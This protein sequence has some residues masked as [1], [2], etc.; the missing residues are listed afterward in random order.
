MGLMTGIILTLLEIP[1]LTA[2]GVAV[3]AC[4]FYYFIIFKSSNPLS[5]YKWNKYNYIW[6]LLLFI[7]LGQFV[8]YL[9]QPTL[10]EDYNKYKV[11]SGIISDIT[12]STSGDRAVVK[13]ERLIDG[14]GKS[15]ENSIIKILLKTDALN[16][17]I[18]DR[19]IFPIELEEIKDSRNYFSIGYTDFLKRKGIYYETFSEGEKIQVIDHSMTFSGLATKIR[20]NLESHIENTHLSK[21]TQN[22]L[23]TVLLGDRSYLDNQ[24]RNLFADAGISHILALSGMHIV[25]IGGI[26]LWLLFPLN[27]FGKYKLRLI[28]TMLLM[29]FYAYITGLNPSTVRATLMMT[30]VF[31][32]ILIERKNTAW[33]SLLL[34]TFII[35]LFN[36]LSLMDV[37]L[38]LSFIC[39]ASLIFFVRQLNPFEQHQH[40]R[41]YKISNAIITTLA[42]TF[43]TW[44]VT[45]Y[46][47]GNVPVVFFFANIIVLPILPIY[48]VISII[49]FFLFGAGIDAKFL[50]NVLD[51][52]YIK[53]LDIVKF[54]SSDGS[55]ALKFSP[56]LISV[57]L[58]CML[59]IV[60]ILIINKNKSR[61]Y[62][63]SGFALFSFFIVSIIFT[64]NADNTDGFIVQNGIGNV[65][66]LTRINGEENLHKIDKQGITSCDILGH[67]LLIMDGSIDRFYGKLKCDE[68]I[69]AGGCKEELKEIL[70]KIAAKEIIIHPSIRKKREQSLINEADSLK[71][72][73]HSI[74]N[75]GPYRK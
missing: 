23:I 3:F 43:A 1:V 50:G 8:S 6:I 12:Q 69:I 65:R 32:C 29:F 7:S 20:D 14:R 2:A 55:T 41:L 19:I 57:V 16:A 58:W 38:Q 27:F 40:P 59:V 26:F 61:I 34:A 45:G 60:I 28:L 44:C 75:D 63:L 48:L 13:I 35:L 24:T 70:N 33:N 56:S 71:I 18:D 72:K 54:V 22:F 64:S 68:L 73:V 31:I 46:Y 67:R 42:V 51:T 66:I 49:Y 37:G 39:V 15:I 9:S 62:K 47:F 21:P 36:P 53:L 17:E 25:I 52:V 4:I 5:A 11:C 30:A 10:I 74:R